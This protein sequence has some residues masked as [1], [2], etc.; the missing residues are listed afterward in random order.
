MGHWTPSTGNINSSEGAHIFQR[1]QKLYC[2]TKNH[3]KLNGFL[4]GYC[5]DIFHHFY[6]IFFSL[7]SFKIDPWK[8][9]TSLRFLPHSFPFCVRAHTY[10]CF[11]ILGSL[12]GWW[13]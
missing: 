7:L 4:K 6:S 13:H 11:V 1:L 5:R 2:T 10:D 8:L 12:L 3:Q 9:E